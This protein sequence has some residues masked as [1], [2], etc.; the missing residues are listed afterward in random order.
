M[1]R[2]KSIPRN[3]LQNFKG[4]G[5]LSYYL[6]DSGQFIIMFIIIIIVVVIAI[7]FDVVIIV[8]IIIQCLLY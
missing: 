7:V 3:I 4:I 8:T 1:T 2:V 5:A 6:H